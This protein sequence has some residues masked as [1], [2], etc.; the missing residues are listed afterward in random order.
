[1]ALEDQNTANLVWMVIAVL[2]GILHCIGI[3]FLLKLGKKKKVSH[4]LLIHLSG[5][6][7]AYLLF[8]GGF[9]I[10]RMVTL[11]VDGF[12]ENSVDRAGSASILVGQ[13]L[14]MFMI[15]GDRFLAV[16]LALK[17]KAVVTGEKLFVLFPTCWVI[18]VVSGCITWYFP[19]V[20]TSL[21]IGWMATLTGTFVIT[22]IYIFTASSSIRKKLNLWVPI[23]IVVSFSCLYLFP[24]VLVE[25]G[26]VKY[27]PWLFVVFVV[28][29]LADSII[30]VIGTKQVKDQLCC[31]SRNNSYNTTNST[32]STN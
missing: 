25:F 21:M 18:S 28:N 6:E 8:R 30:Y 17:Y 3:H 32:N 19:K 16:K 29:I 27:S 31:S 23:S 26:L 20:L 5:T 24:A 15:T 12:K 22:Y 7:I 9:V 1:M 11:T 10:K 4:V 13:Y 2:A 14:S